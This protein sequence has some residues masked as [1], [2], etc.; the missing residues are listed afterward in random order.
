MRRSCSEIVSPNDQILVQRALSGDRNAL[1]A[2]VR[3]VTPVIQARVARVLHAR[4]RRAGA[5]VRDEVED[6][7]QQVFLSLF[8]RDAHV[9]RVWDPQRGLSLKNFVGL[10]AER[11]AM[12][13]A[14]RGRRSPCV[15]QDD[16]SVDRDAAAEGQQLVESFELQVES[17]DILLNVVHTLRERLSPLGL[18]LFEML[19]VDQMP[20]DEVASAMSMTAVAVY[21]WSSRLAKQARAIASEFAQEH[22]MSGSAA[23]AGSPERQATS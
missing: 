14:R 10:V 5:A 13:I 6:I 1:L 18:Q 12:S 7:T 22:T 15:V 20:V 23:S 16:N 3:L 9:L 19:V 2:F 4:G 11:D 21:A 17:R 8:E